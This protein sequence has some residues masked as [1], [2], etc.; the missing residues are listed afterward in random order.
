MC[1]FQRGDVWWFQFFFAGKRIQESTKS[2]SKTIALAAEKQRRRELEDEYNGVAPAES[3]IQRVRLLAD[4]AADFLDA[5]M[6][7][8]KSPS[9]GKYC[10]LHLTKY[11]GAK[12]IST[13]N[14]AT[15]LQYQTDRI[16]DGASGKTINDEVQF[17]LRILGDRGKQIRASLKD[18]KQLHRPVNK[19]VGKKFDIRE[20]DAMIAAARN[21]RSPHIY[22]A[23]VIA[24]TTGMRAAEIRELQWHQVDF[25]ERM[26]TVGKMETP[27]GTLNRGKTEGSRGRTIP[28]GPELLPVL[29]EHAAWYKKTLGELKPMR[30][31]FPFGRRGRLNP[32]RHVTTIK[33][34]WKTVR[35]EAGA[36]GRWHDTRH[37]MASTLAASGVPDRVIMKITGHTTLSSLARYSHIGTEEKRDALETI[38]ASR[39]AA[40]AKYAERENAK[41]QRSTTKLAAVANG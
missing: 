12:M 14:V 31:L 26:I 21:S 8:V 18:D 36:K 37:T 3:K 34:A 25:E 41:R 1:V 2:T 19:D 29:T 9:F 13:I 11:L 15:V 23:L 6:V 32:D 24:L 22:A 38:A 39:Q 5:Y 4:V 17:L 28:I 33:S 30:Y 10:V 27:E 40:R 7:R 35:A 16:K 20:Q